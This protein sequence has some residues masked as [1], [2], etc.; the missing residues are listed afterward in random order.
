[1]WRSRLAGIAATVT[2]SVAVLLMAAGRLSAAQPT[3]GEALT[4]VVSTEEIGKVWPGEPVW[5]ALLR[6]AGWIF[7]AFYDE[8]RFLTIAW[9]KESGGEYSAFHN[10]KSASPHRARA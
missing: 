4:R 10:L 7:V 2:V 6:H 8:D 1:M 9:R 3:P 5:F